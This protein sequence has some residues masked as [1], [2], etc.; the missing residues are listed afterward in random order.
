MI[1]I[2][3]NSF[4]HFDN[5]LEDDNV[6]KNFHECAERLEKIAKHYRK[7]ADFLQEKNIKVE[8]VEGYPQS[9]SFTVDEIDYHRLKKADLIIN[10]DNGESDESDNPVFYVDS[11]LDIALKESVENIDFS[12]LIE[13]IPQGDISGDEIKE[14]E[15]PADYVETVS[16]IKEF[17]D[18]YSNRESDLF[19]GSAT[20]Y[21]NL[22]KVFKDFTLNPDH[23]PDL[24]VAVARIKKF[25][26]EQYAFDFNIQDIGEDPVQIKFDRAKGMFGYKCANCDY[27]HLETLLSC[28]KSLKITIAIISHLI[29][30]CGDQKELGIVLDAIDGDLRLIQHLLQFDYALEDETASESNSNDPDEEDYDDLEPDFEI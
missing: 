23:D 30:M 7:M 24:H 29:A 13:V 19:E 5:E 9:G 3:A 27:W 6:S 14:K 10:H 21:I 26:S 12:K 15:E 20:T 1:N 22:A 4:V 25:T 17:Q 28:Y 2:H 8:K 11:E 16:L 18:N